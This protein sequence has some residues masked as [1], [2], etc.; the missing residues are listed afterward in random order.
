[1][2]LR[3]GQVMPTLYP[4]DH[5]SFSLGLHTLPTVQARSPI[6]SCFVILNC[7][8]LHKKELYFN[9][10]QNNI[11]TS[12]QLNEENIQN[13]LLYEFRCTYLDIKPTKILRFMSMTF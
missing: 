9:I 4:T 13:T 12:K 6:T 10:L 8:H 7:C 2:P 5:I 1:M 3:V 11:A